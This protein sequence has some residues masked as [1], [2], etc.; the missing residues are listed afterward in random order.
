MLG[1]TLAVAGQ[2][3]L[4][5]RVYETRSA[6]H[7]VPGSVEA[8]LSAGVLARAFAWP[9]ALLADALYLGGSADTVRL[10]ALA[11]SVQR[12]GAR[13]YYARDWTLYHHIRGLIAVRAGRWGEAE[14]EFS[15]ARFGRSGWTRTLFEL[16]K[17]QLKLGRPR[18]ALTTLRDAH[19]EPLD[20]MGRYATRSELDLL[21]AQAFVAAGQR[22]SAAVYAGYVRTAWANADPALKPRLSQLP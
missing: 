19:E 9:H 12:I 18:A 10:A 5:A 15:A 4:A 22:D 8:D 17:V 21:T 13:S 6:A 11:D 20:G 2:P 16:A 7:P 14:R 1:H 3:T